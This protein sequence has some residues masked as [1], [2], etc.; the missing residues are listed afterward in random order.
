MKDIKKIIDKVVFKEWMTDEQKALIVLAG[1]ADIAT[2]VGGTI[3]S[4][5]IIKNLAAPKGLI[6][7]MGAV[8]LSCG[9]GKFAGM[10]FL[11]AAIDI[12]NKDH[13]MEEKENVA[14]VVEFK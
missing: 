8:G 13:E 12:L 3:I 10:D 9:V 11:A 6:Q 5:N 1:C 4:F 2:F 7:K 14:E